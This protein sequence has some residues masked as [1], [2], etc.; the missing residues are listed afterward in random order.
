MKLLWTKSSKPLSLL[1][2]AITGEDCSHFSF[3]LYDGKPGEIMF[4][5]NLLGTHPVF[6][7]TAMK[8]H[9]IVHE[10]NIAL[11]QYIEDLIWDR[12]VSVYDNQEYD[13]LGALYLGYRTILYRL[14]GIPKPERNELSRPGSYYCDEIF[15]ALNDVPKLPVLNVNG[16]MLTPHEVYEKVIGSLRHG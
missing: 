1:I 11:D 16:G 15:D 4:E 2:R 13:F 3:V 8:T 9:I 7:K 5:S 6:Y 14:L 12:I 10:I